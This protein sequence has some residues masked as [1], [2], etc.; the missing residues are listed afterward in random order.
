MQ[1]NNNNFTKCCNSD[2]GFLP[3]LLAFGLLP[4][5]L[6]LCLMIFCLYDIQSEARQRSIKALT[7]CDKVTLSHS[8]YLFHGL[9]LGI[10][11]LNPDANS[12]SVNPHPPCDNC[13]AQLLLQRLKNSSG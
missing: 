6:Q 10:R 13:S 4:I 12:A 2:R 1:N 8:L 3:R 5:N 9:K 7:G 11:P